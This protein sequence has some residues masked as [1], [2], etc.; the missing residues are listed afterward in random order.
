MSIKK[1]LLLTFVCV[2]IIPFLLFGSIG[3]LI[4]KYQ[5]SL[6]HNQYNTEVDGWQAIQSPMLVL[7]RLTKNIFNDLQYTSIVTPDRFLEREY[8]TEIN[9]RLSERQAFLVVYREDKLLFCGNNLVYNIVADSIPELYVQSVQIDGGLYISGDYPCLVKQQYF[10]YTDGSQGAFII[11]S[12]ANTI[13]PQTKQS[14]FLALVALIVVF[15]ISGGFILFWLYSGIAKPL[16]QL[17]T[18]ARRVKEGDLDF[19]LDRTGADEIG[20]LSTDF[21]EMR[22][23]LKGEIDARLA[24][25]E[26]LRNLIGN[27]SHDLKTP[28]TIINGYAEGLIDGVAA[29]PEKREKYVRMIQRKA[30]DASLMVE[31]LALYAKIESKAYPYYFEEVHL[32]DF[33]ADCIEEDTFALDARNITISMDTKRLKDTDVVS[34]DREQ[35]KRVTVNIIGN[36]AKYLGKESGSILIRLVDEGDY[37]RTEIIDDGVGIPRD[38]LPHIFE[39]FYRGD[40]SRNSNTG[41]SG[42]GLSIVK[43]IVEGHKGK[44]YAFSKEGEGTTIAFSLLK[45]RKEETCQES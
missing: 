3:V 18:A 34:A 5:T 44:I 24:Y 12:D 36:A 29:T 10:T 4:I 15:F 17:E 40:K 8:Q 2:T 43:E 14:L 37:I 27:I 45:A 11:I 13:M 33:Y 7:N 32:K 30:Q 28:L 41:G 25:E 16:K 1:R 26:D 42:L 22:A 9:E 38:T 20:D 39:R 31:E 6:M 21:E 19:R 35:L 23:H